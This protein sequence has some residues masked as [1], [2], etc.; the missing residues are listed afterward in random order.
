MQQEK[1]KDVLKELLSANIKPSP[2]ESADDFIKRVKEHHLPLVKKIA[3]A[4]MGV[5]DGNFENKSNVP[6]DIVEKIN[7]G[8][9]VSFTV[10]EDSPNYKEVRESLHQLLKEL[11]AEEVTEN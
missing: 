8:K 5:I 3:G 6:D 11:G 9:C 1:I 10:P 7:T 2:D 4:K